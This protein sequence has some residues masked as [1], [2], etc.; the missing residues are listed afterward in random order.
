MPVTFSFMKRRYFIYTSGVVALGTLPV[1]RTFASVAKPGMR[2]ESYARKF[3]SPAIDAKIEE[4]KSKVKDE[5]IAW[6]FENCFP[7]T[8]DTTVNFDLT[9]EGV[10]DT[11]VITGDI[12]A[13]WLRDSSAQVFPYIRFCKDDDQLRLMIEGVIRRHTKCILLDPYANAFYKDGNKTSPWHNDHTEMKPGVHERKYELDSLCYPIR[14]A[15]N[16]WKI[17][18]HT[19]PFDADWLSAMKLAVATMKEQQRKDGPGPYTFQRVGGASTDNLPNRGKGADIK[20][21]GMICSAFRNSDDACTYLFNIPENLFASVVLMNLEEMIGQV[22][23]DGN[24]ARTCGEL[25]REVAAAARQYGII[26][27]PV[28]TKMYA[29]E[30]DG[31]GKTLLMDDAG[32]PGLMAIP[33]LGFN[34]IH[35]DIY[36]NSRRFALSKDN[37]YF[38]KSEKFEGLGS[39]HLAWKHADMIWPLGIIMRAL[40]TEDDNEITLCLNMLKASH[41]GKGFMHEGFNKDKPEDFTRS[42]FAWANSLFGELILKL[43]NEKPYLI[44]AE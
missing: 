13:M 14:L 2:P 17:T 11:Y 42:W 10:P 25:G 27:H 23:K 44:K 12:D 33:Y 31:N 38:Y 41:A 3:R 16:Y 1:L 8:L 4:V 22:T 18:G 6:L 28:Y 29:Y 32:I 26:T 20:P 5:E 35:D 15:Y 43:Y 39:P 30:C 9:K 40:T 36:Q 21:V 34:D 24:F 37:P 19:T 7:N